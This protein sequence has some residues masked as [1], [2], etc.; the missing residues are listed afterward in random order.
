MPSLLT[1]PEGSE[2]AKRVPESDWARKVAFI[3]T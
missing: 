1:R 3:P 2:Y